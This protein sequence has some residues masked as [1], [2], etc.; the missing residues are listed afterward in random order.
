L[1]G[2]A[3]TEALS[4]GGISRPV[5]TTLTAAASQRAVRRRRG[6]RRHARRLR[7]PLRVATSL[8]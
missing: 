3:A 8:I 4:T 5:A 1:V 7:D 2:G 6:D